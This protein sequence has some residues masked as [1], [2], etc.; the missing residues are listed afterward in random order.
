M[1][2]SSGL[3]GH[4]VRCYITLCIEVSRLRRLREEVSGMRLE[5]GQAAP[6]FTLP[7]QNGA[8]HSLSDYR[9]HWVLVYFY[10]RDNT[11]GCTK[12][13]CTIRDGFQDFAKF[14]AV[15]LGISTD[16]TESHLKF[17]GKYRLPFT[18]LSDGE[19]EAVRKYGVWGEKKLMGKEYMGTRRMSF[20][21]DPEGRI[22]KIYEKVKPAGH[23][24]EVLEDLARLR[25]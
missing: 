15:V 12:E 21:I 5:V 17:A 10:P 2:A 19:K 8:M 23:A 9:G 16:S 22:A 1:R 14:N 11:P 25:T 24:A 3:I 20:L 13:A 4:P 18:L 7:D 6:P